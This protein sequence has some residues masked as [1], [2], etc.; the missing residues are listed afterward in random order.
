MNNDKTTG[1][2]G[3][4]HYGAGRGM[5]VEGNPRLCA[6]FLNQMLDI[7]CPSLENYKGENKGPG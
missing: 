3:E 6:L 7:K 2:G 4:N 5:Y 1:G